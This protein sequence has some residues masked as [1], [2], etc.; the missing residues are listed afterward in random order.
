MVWGHATPAVL[1]HTSMGDDLDS[2]AKLQLRLDHSLISFNEHT[3]KAS[4]ARSPSVVVE[5]ACFLLQHGALDVP[6]VGCINVK[7]ARALLWNAVWLQE[8]MNEQWRAE[9]SGGTC[10]VGDSEASM[11]DEFMLAIIGDLV[12]PARQRFSKLLR[13]SPSFSKVL[14]PRARWLRP[15][16]QLVC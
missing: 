3:P 8:H 6:D 2:D 12:V 1:Q 14:T 4:C 5:A 9:D 7:Q 10:R 15:M 16:Q 11:A 13:R